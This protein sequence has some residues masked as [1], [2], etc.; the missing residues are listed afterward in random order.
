[1]LVGSLDVSKNEE[2][3]D[4][5]GVDVVIVKKTNRVLDDRLCIR[6]RVGAWRVLFEPSGEYIH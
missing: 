5:C 1:M 2:W 4:I 6:L 3:I